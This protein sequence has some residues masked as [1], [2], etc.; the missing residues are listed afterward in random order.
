MK[1]VLIAIGSVVLL[2]AALFA[3]NNHIYT[4]KQADLPATNTPAISTE[5]VGEPITVR[6]QI[7]CLPKIGDGPQ[8]Q[9]CAI[10][11]EDESGDYYSLEAPADAGID[12]QLLGT[13][14]TVE[15]SGRLTDEEQLGPDGN[16]YDT[17]G[18]IVIE[19]IEAQ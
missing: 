11:L 7:T 1:N 13:G 9:E 17:V 5:A 10:G 3:L 8:T 12:Y 4:E 16:R 15:V 2:I 19:S 6:G 18:T 14:M